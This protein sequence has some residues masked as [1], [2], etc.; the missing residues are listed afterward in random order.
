MG[1]EIM[2]GDED[3]G[4]LTKE[5]GRKGSRLESVEHAARTLG[6]V[7]PDLIDDEARVQG[8]IVNTE[9]YEEMCEENGAFPDKDLT[10]GVKSGLKTRYGIDFGLSV[11]GEA[12]EYMK[13][14]NDHDK[15][16]DVI[17]EAQAAVDEQLS[18]DEDE[19]DE[20]DEE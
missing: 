9:E 10:S 4:A 19:E 3:A 5:S 1:I 18:D 6:K 12:G 2:D 7:H 20:E 11:T 15:F 17:A 16:A 14:P 8:I 13:I